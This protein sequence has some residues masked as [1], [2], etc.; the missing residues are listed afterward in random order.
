MTPPIKEDYRLF[1][2]LT[3]G[4][5]DEGSQE[6]PSIQGVLCKVFLPKRTA[7]RPV[8][9]F[10]PNNEQAKRLRALHVVSVRAELTQPNGY[11]NI[12]NSKQT[13]I[14][15]N[16]RTAWGPNLTEHVLIG[17]P[18]D[19]QVETVRHDA[20]N[21]E[22]A[23]TD[24]SFQLS[25]NQL[26]SNVFERSFSYTGDVTIQKFDPLRVTLANDLT[27][28]FTVH[29]RYLDL[30]SDDTVMFD[31][32]VAEF[33]F[34]DDV[35]HTS[36]ITDSIEHLEDVLRLVSFVGEYPCVCFG[37]RAVDSRSVMDFYRNRSSSAKPAPSV[38]DALIEY[39]DF[40]DFITSAH[41]AFMEV[42][43][44]AAL[45]RALDY[46]VPDQAD[47]IESSY[48]MLYAAVE[49]LILFF[50]RREH[51]E[52]I[53]SDESEWMTVQADLKSLLSAHPVFSN[54]KVK[55]ARVYEKLS[56]LTRPSFSSAFRAFC[57][58]YH[59][60]LSD[61]WPMVGSS[62]GDS[63]STIRNKIVHGEV[64]QHDKYE[65]LMGARAHLR[66][67]IYRMI[68]GMLQWPI[69]RTKVGEKH[70]GRHP[71]HRTLAS[72]IKLLSS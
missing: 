58:H 70:I 17:D 55:R 62:K 24:G 4:D 45:R 21:P 40:E 63:L 61:L 15:R 29:S 50:R 31:E 6:E 64:Y 23:H 39:K 10:L 33:I 59:V 35:L 18:W 72:D 53:F 11:I 30:P 26:L 12:I 57:D 16:K 25:N 34:P 9:H 51:L 2:I 65:A 1:A 42:S 69:G 36:A 7:D 38:H 46:V 32:N 20:G 66:W 52:F 47:S 68:F 19:L 27:I 41:K 37:W 67:S 60:D 5:A 49:T 8:L 71:I 28:S 3:V 22:A 54:D 13:L 14:I 48:I 44:N 43:P 56:E